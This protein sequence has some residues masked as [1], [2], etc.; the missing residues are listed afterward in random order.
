MKK[1]I[2][3]ASVNPSKKLVSREGCSTSAGSNFIRLEDLLDVDINYDDIPSG[4]IIIFDAGSRKWVS[5]TIDEVAPRPTTVAK[6]YVV[7]NPS[8]NWV[9]N[10][11][12][13]TTNFILTIRDEV[14]NIIVAPSVINSENA[15]TIEMSKS[16]AGS[17]DVHFSIDP[18]V[19][20][21]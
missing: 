6:Y 14:G 8:K 10:H 15:F 5:T 9:I 18:E 16:I 19:I 21:I 17:V 1:R 3:T 20:Y 4:T 11:N 13:G 7:T 2:I 12:M